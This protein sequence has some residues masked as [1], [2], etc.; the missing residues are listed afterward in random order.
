MTECS[1]DPES[2]LSKGPH[3]GLGCFHP[4]FLPSLFHLG[5]GLYHSLTAP[6]PFSL[7][8]SQRKAASLQGCTKAT[9]RGGP[10]IFKRM[11]EDN[12]TVFLHH[13]F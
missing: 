4:A 12:P 13:A 1:R 3:S 11:W 7:T 5:S 8:G 10:V 2:G 9:P 6:S